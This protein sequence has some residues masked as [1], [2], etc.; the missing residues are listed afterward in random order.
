VLLDRK[1][2]I[3]TDLVSPALIV[4]LDCFAGYGIDKL[5]A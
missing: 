2:L 3:S 1:K 5:M 4:P